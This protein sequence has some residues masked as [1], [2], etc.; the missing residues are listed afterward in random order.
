MQFNPFQIQVMECRMN[1]S[2]KYLT[3]ISRQRLRKK[4]PWLG[5]SVV[6]GIVKE[7]GGS[8]KVH[9]EIDK[10]SAF[11]I[12]L[13]LIEKTRS[14]ESI[15]DVEGI[16]GGNE[17]ILLV[18]DEEAIAKLEKLML[19]SMGY[20]VTSYISGADALETFKASPFS[21]D[22]VVTDMSM[23]NIPGD[24]LAR[25]IKSIRT[26]VPVIICTGFS[27]RIHQDNYEQM[28]IDALLMKPIA[29][30]ELAKVVRIVLN[31]S[32]N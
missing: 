22:L 13:P 21:Y 2:A 6:Y 19:E 23:P 11:D 1:L 7:Y 17:R 29:T 18:D 26:D 5:L 8:I 30:S 28:G 16:P 20:D 25:E 15:P 12:Y 3:R 31:E 32:K 14:T 24:E 9:S 27:E 10:G 4:G